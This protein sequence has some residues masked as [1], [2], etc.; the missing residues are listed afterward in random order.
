MVESNVRRQR[1][2]MNMAVAYILI[3]TL[4]GSIGQVLLKKGMS[5]MGPLT[6]TADQLGPVLWRMAT[7]P[8][9]IGG[10]LVYGLATVFWLTALSRVPLSFAYPFVSLNFLVILVVSWRL[11]GEEISPWRVLGTLIVGV[12]VLLIS[13]T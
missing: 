8:Y 10:L 3:G 4:G 5:G 6:L 11:F 9:V 1:I 13:K 7:S 2:K 12:G